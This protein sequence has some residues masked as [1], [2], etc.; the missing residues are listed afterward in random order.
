MGLVP[1]SKII[2]FC[3]RDDAYLKNEHSYK[4]FSYHNYRNWDC[5]LFVES[6][7]CLA[8]KGYSVIR[9]GSLT[10]KK[11]ISNNPNIID[12]ANSKF[13]SD[14]MDFYLGYK[15]FFCVTTATGMDSF[16]FFFRKKLAQIHLPIHAPWTNNNNLISSCHHY[17]LKEKRLL[18]I[19][20]IFYYL[21]KIN[22]KVNSNNLKNLGIQIQY[23]SKE[24]LKDFCLEAVNKFDGNVYYSDQDKN[25]QKQF[26]E[27]FNENIKKYNLSSVHGPIKASF[28][29]NFL[30]SNLDWI[31]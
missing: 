16:S 24:H 10:K 8:S 2:L 22:F 14:F 1:N 5:D 17:S 4:D 20:E 9:M 3:I 23:H 29:I 28:D 26:W 21:N 30:R 11:F 25:I 19:S 13:R 12:Y 15:S 6:A 31:N 18:N 27:I 7:E